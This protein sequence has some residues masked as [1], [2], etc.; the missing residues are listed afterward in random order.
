MSAFGQFMAMTALVSALAVAASWMAAG[1]SAEIVQSGSLVTHIYPEIV[2]KTLIPNGFEPA[3][4]YPE[5][6]G[7]SGHTGKNSA[8]LKTVDYVG[9]LGRQFAA[10]AERRKYDLTDMEVQALVNEVSFHSRS[11]GAMPLFVHRLDE[12]DLDLMADYGED[13]LSE[14][15]DETMQEIGWLDNLENRISSLFRY[16]LSFGGAERRKYSNREFE[17]ED[18]K[19]TLRQQETTVVRTPAEGRGRDDAHYGMSLVNIDASNESVVGAPS[20]YVRWEKL[21]AIDKVKFKVQPLEEV[22]LSLRDTI[23]ERWY[24]QTKALL[25]G[26]LDPEM[27]FNLTRRDEARKNRL[28]FFAEFGKHAHVG[29]MF[30]VLL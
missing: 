13:V 3:M 8:A 25:D 22:S 17:W 30:G 10:E 29:I 2:T 19:E 11:V 16:E 18:R 27:R 7:Q 23:N 6:H 21:P 5:G 26:G 9:M 20:A 14:A 28:T 4:I 15:A 1:V 12:Q 24:W